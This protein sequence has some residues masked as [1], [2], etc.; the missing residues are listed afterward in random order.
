MCLMHT[1]IITIDPASNRAKN[2]VTSDGDAVISYNPS[3][4]VPCVR[5][6]TL[7]P[8]D[9][10]GTARCWIIGGSFDPERNYLLHVTNLTNLSIL[11]HRSLSPALAQKALHAQ[12]LVAPRLTGKFEP[13]GT[14]AQREI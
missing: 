3:P 2:R 11:L 14:L 6:K 1:V 10:T 7:S 5:G 4:V 8:S 12:A 13:Y 9:K